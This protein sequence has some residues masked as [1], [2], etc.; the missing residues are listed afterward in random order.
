MHHLAALRRSDPLAPL[1]DPGRREYRRLVPSVAL[2]AQITVAGASGWRLVQRVPRDLSLCGVGLSLRWWERGR[3]VIGESVTLSLTIPQGVFQLSGTAV[4][5]DP[6]RR[7]LVTSRS[8]G[9]QLTSDSDY[10]AAQPSLCQYL[11]SL[12]AERDAAR[13]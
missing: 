13:G 2:P 8:L 4:A 12:A 9:I 7:G 10:G 5:M 3:V 11:L 6:V 1:R